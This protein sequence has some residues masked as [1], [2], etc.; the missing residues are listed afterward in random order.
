MTLAA[1]QSALQTY[2]AELLVAVEKRR[3]LLNNLQVTQKRVADM[4]GMPPLLREDCTE[5]A[6]IVCADIGAFN[7]KWPN[8]AVEPIRIV[9]A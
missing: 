1:H 2:E 4:S 8:L 3:V 7:R 6:F 9:G 5:A